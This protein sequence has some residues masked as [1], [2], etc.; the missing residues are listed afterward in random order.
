MLPPTESPLRLFSFLPARN[1]GQPKF[2][3][4]AMASSQNGRTMYFRMPTIR[5]SITSITTADCPPKVES[6]QLAWTIAIAS[7]A[8]REFQKEP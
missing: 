1:A 3:Y 2:Y 7:F 8:T 4:A 5:D 6:P